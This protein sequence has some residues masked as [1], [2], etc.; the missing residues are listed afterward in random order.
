MRPMDLRCPSG[1][2]NGERV[3]IGLT[4]FIIFLRTQEF[5]L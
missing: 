4:F 2:M 3:A 5:E 1:S